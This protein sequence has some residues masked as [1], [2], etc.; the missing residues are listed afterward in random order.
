M[1]AL[2]LN[3]FKQQVLGDRHNGGKTVLLNE[4]GLVEKPRPC[5]AEWFFLSGESPLR[6]FFEANSIFSFFPKLEFYG[7]DLSKV[8]VVSF[9][10]VDSNLLTETHAISVSLAVGNLL[11][12]SQWFGLSDLHCEN[13]KY[14]IDYKNNFILA[15][16]DVECVFQEIK[17]PFQ[18][19]LIQKNINDENFGLKNLINS[20]ILLP[21]QVVAAYL[22][23]MEVLSS[24]QE[25][26]YKIINDVF[27][28]TDISRILLKDTKMYR[29]WNR[30]PEDFYQ[31]EIVQLKAGDIP[32]FFRQLESNQINYWFKDNVTPL[33]L[34]SHSHSILAQVVLSDLN[35][36]W[37]SLRKY[38]RH[39]SLQIT[40]RLLGSSQSYHEVSPGLEL[41]KKDNQIEIITTHWRAKCAL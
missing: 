9:L 29:S 31:E 2:P 21:V 19:R 12:I 28:A 32:Y 35:I 24:Q 33:M 15:P 18:T 37:E 40:D 11:A 22:E 41:I 5:L 23:T 20:K 13:I 8:G 3:K 25:Q 27:N 6:N 34:S 14:G 30:T 1:S 16:I 7:D 39:G 36:Y 4:K 10:N 17:L 38:V 26:V